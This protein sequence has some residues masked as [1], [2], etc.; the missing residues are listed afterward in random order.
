MKALCMPF[1]KYPYHFYCVST[2]YDAT[3]L[4]LI[5]SDES[6]DVAELHHCFCIET[7]RQIVH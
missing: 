3:S 5:R 7:L 6:F 4:G 1:V 2:T